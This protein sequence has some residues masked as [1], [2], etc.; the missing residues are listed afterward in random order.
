MAKTKRDLEIEVKELTLALADI[1]ESTEHEI[2]RY[3]RALAQAQ[4]DLTVDEVD[5]RPARAVYACP[6]SEEAVKRA[7]A[8]WGRNVTEP[9]YEGDWQRINTY[10]KGS[11]GLGWSWEDD[12]THN[13]QFSWCGAFAAFA[14]GQSVLPSIRKKIFPSCYRMWANWGASS[15]CRDGENPLPGDIVTVYTSS[16]K[17]PSYGNHIVLCVSAIDGE[18]YF[19]TIEGNAHGE[20]PEGR[21][22]GV[23]KRT[24]HMS[25]V[26]HIYRLLSEDYEA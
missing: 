19:H 4:I 2:R 6:Q 8:E 9:E 18:G 20:G 21:I 16:D 1:K 11:E 23:I 25:N 5:T 26:A 17:S 14:Y 7:S 3:K 13:G 22:E 24:R 15:R 12:Y 10:I